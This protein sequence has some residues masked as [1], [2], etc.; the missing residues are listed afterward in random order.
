MESSNTAGHLLLPWFPPC[1]DQQ[2]PLWIFRESMQKQVQALSSHGWLPHTN[3]DPRL[4][5]KEPVTVTHST[6]ARSCIHTLQ[7]YNR[8]YTTLCHKCLRAPAKVAYNSLEIAYIAATAR[9]F[10]AAFSSVARGAS[11][12][13]LAQLAQQLRMRVRAVQ[14]LVERCPQTCNKACKWLP[15]DEEKVRKNLRQHKSTYNK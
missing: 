15:Q 6:G 3:L 11:P 8:V 5:D 4:R 12:I 10:A 14:D 9:V 13:Q 2:H 7:Q 1:A